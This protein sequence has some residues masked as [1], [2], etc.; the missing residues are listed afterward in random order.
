MKL[1]RIFPP[2][3]DLFSLMAVPFFVPFV[4]IFFLSCW[5]DFAGQNGAIF[6]SLDDV[7]LLYHTKRG[8]VSKLHCL[9][10]KLHIFTSGCPHLERFKNHILIQTLHIL[11]LPSLTLLMKFLVVH[12]SIH[13]LCLN[14]KFFY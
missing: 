12:K 13:L 11:Y 10:T 6:I 8:K 1:D 5:L 2:F 3:S 4:P 14:S 7:A 9:K